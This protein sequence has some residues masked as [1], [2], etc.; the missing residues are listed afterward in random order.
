MYRGLETRRSRTTTFV[1]LCGSLPAPVCLPRS[2]ASGWRLAPADDAGNM[3]VPGDMSLRASVGASRGC[4]PLLGERLGIGG[5]VRT[6]VSVSERLHCLGFAPFCMPR[7]ASAYLGPKHWSLWSVVC[8]LKNHFVG[9]E[10]LLC[11]ANT[12]SQRD[13]LLTD[14]SASLSYWDQKPVAG[15]GHVARS[16]VLRGLG[17]GKGELAPASSPEAVAGPGDQSHVLLGQG[18]LPATPAEPQ[19][20]WAISSSLTCISASL[21]HRTPVTLPL[22]LLFPDSSGFSLSACS[23]QLSRAAVIKR[24]TPYEAA[25]ILCCGSCRR[26]WS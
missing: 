7:S 8:A 24:L 14:V 19:C 2:L 26:S 17:A 13:H 9:S 18:L 22:S 5:T 1:P 12:T 11:V 23:L 15:A 20:T 21:Q 3:H 25:P 6:R 10:L 16:W 4:C